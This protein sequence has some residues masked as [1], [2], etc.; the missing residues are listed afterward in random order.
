MDIFELD[1]ILKDLCMLISN[2][3]YNKHSN[4]NVFRV[5]DKFSFLLGLNVISVEIFIKDTFVNKKGD[6]KEVLLNE[7][8]APFL[9]PFFTNF[10]K[11]IN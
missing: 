11:E 2:E 8:Q 4:E 10:A 5:T 1:A 9:I 6:I 3:K 7:Q